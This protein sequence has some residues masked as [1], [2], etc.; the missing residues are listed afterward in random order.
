M[1][2]III[3]A[4][5]EL[6]AT[7]VRQPHLFLLEFTFQ[8]FHPFLELGKKVLCALPLNNS[9]STCDVQEHATVQSI[10]QLSTSAIRSPDL[11]LLSDLC[12]PCR[13][14]RMQKAYKG[15]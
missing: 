6:E 4:E 9:S 12:W 3:Q 11:S 8:L 2:G 10:F 15:Q 14:S 7:R 5:T 1:Y 13:G